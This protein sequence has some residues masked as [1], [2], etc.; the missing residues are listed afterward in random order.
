LDLKEKRGYTALMRAV[1]GGHTEVAKMLAKML[2]DAG[3][4]LDLQDEH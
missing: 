1:H 3:D 4:N 2:A